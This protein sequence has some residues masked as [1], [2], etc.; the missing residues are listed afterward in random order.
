MLSALQSGAVTVRQDEQPHNQEREEPHPS[1]PF[2]TREITA[3]KTLVKEENLSS[4]SEIPYQ[5]RS[6]ESVSEHCSLQSQLS[7]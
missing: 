3:N 6:Y 4:S 1:C 7:G 2:L 5:Y